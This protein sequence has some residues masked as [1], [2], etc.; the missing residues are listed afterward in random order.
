MIIL[1]GGA[2]FIG[3]CFLWKLN[4]E[5]IK[6]VLVVDNLNDSEKWKNLTGKKYKDYIQKNDFYNAVISDNAPSP[7]AVAYRRVQ[8]H[9]SYRRGLLCKKQL[10]I[11][12]SY[13]FMGF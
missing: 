12:K 2:G 13:G 3:S 1:T 10:R 9:Y 8:L 11:F 7:S 5:S 4:Q 6:D